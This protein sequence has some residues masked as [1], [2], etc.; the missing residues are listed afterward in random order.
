MGVV[1]DRFLRR[2]AKMGSLEEVGSEG[3]RGRGERMGW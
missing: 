2:L 3:E 1:I